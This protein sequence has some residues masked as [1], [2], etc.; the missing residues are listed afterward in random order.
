MKDVMTSFDVAAATREINQT[1]EGA[2]ISKIY[3]IGT[4]T[5]LLKLRK[6]GIP[7][8][9]LLIEAGKRVHL[10]SYA[11]ETP[12]RPSGFCMSLRKYLDNGVIQAVKQHAFER[13]VTI[14]I[15]TR[16]GGFQLISEFFGNGNIILVDPEQKILQAMTYKR[17][18]DRNILRNE[19]F[20][21]P[22]SRGKNPQSLSIQEF[23]EIKES[24]DKEIVRALSRSVSISGVYAEEI[25]LRS[26]VNKKTH[27]NDLTEE[28]L[29]TIFSELQNLLSAIMSK[30]L[31]PSIISDENDQWID[32]TAVSRKKYEQ[33]KKQK[34]E[35]FNNALDEYYAKIMDIETT[36]EATGDVEKEV[37]RQKRI[38]DKQLHA[39]EDLKEPIIKNKHIGD[40]IYQ[41]F[42][43]FQTLSQKILEQKDL[44]KS[45]EE[46]ASALQTGKKTNIHPA[47]LFESLDGK[48]QVLRVSVGENAF[49]LNLRDSIQD[50]ANRYYLKSK[51][52]EKK[53]KGA[54]KIFE[55]T[56]VKIEKAKKQV[57]LTQKEQQP[58]AKRRKKEWYEKFRWFHSSDGFLV[59]GGRDATT[60]EL[61]VKKRM[62]P[63]DIIFHA[64]IV[65]APFVLIKTEGKTV[66][67]QTINEAAQAAASYS[68][69]WKELL[70]AINV[71]WIH[72]DQVSKTPP[73]GQS[74]PKGSFMIRGKKNFVRGTKLQVAIG[75][76][77]KDDTII[78]VG[79]PV[80]AIANQTDFYMEL[81]PGTQKSS[82]IAKKFRHTLST[83]VPEE[84]KR[85]VTGIELDEFQRFIPLGRGK[86]IRSKR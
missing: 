18:K 20:Q 14:E 17:M 8:I 55:E 34:F 37:A 21:Y 22:P 24:G 28:E 5:I 9:Q 2:F 25:L 75:L 38:L 73:S 46:I 6:P 19:P 7:R 44:G 72:P 77:I 66:P 43:D 76:K 63:N 62:E 50:N 39:L 54:E 1:V 23:K 32:V 56:R 31:E 86:I 69:A 64:E 30:K 61:I 67:E 26:G 11:H 74:L 3:Q 70:S 81:I 16:Q 10:T 79:G 42:G 68:R 13:I 27:C 4:K 40:L 85:T 59:I 58:L 15:N 84:L 83:K 53:L 48:N 60:N 65:G 49:S 51:K 57:V 82:E 52:A 35:T 41:H 33:F 80:D 29:E 78:L 36:Q 45:W 12:Q 71:Y 47:T